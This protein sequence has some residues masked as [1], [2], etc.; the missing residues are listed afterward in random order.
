MCSF[1]TSRESGTGCGEISQSNGI[2]NGD[3]EGEVFGRCVEGVTE[4]VCQ[5]MGR[6]LVLYLEFLV[7]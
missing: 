7:S 2:R 6:L 3:R 1:I 5:K 4:E